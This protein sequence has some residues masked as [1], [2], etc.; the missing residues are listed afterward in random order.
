MAEPSNLTLGA[1][2]TD[3][4][5]DVLMDAVYDRQRHFYDF[6]RKYY[7]LGRDRLISDLAMQPGQT[8][9]EVGCGTGR[10]LIAV[11][12][13]YPQA[14]LYGYDISEK[15]LETAHEKIT[16]AGLASRI[17][18]RQ[19]DAAR[20]DAAREFGRPMDRVFFSYTLSMIPPWQR[21]LTNNLRALSPCGSLHVVDFGQQ[22]R[23]PA[24]FRFLLHGW[25]ARF[26][27]E[28]RA[29][30]LE[31]LDAAGKTAGRQGNV[32]LLYRGYAWLGI[33]A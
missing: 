19:G 23:L 20:F 24:A 7:L 25:L 16:R 6:T 17:T 15:M 28:P 32:R 8:A 26:H 27:V 4:R 10:N 30:L 5:H 22:E 3:G 12:R 21:A 11:A 31:T 18:L 9:L 1:P 14:C 13:R 2:Q 29:D 33:I